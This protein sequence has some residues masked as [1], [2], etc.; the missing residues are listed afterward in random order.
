MNLIF[1]M[2]LTIFFANRASRLMP[3]DLASKSMRVLPTDLDVQMHMNNGRFLSIMDLGRVDLMVRLGFWGIARQRGWYPLVGSVK[4]DYRRPLTVFQ[5][6]DM[7]T[8]IV[9]WDDRWVFVEQQLL[10]DGKLCA[11]AMF[12]TMI[13]CKEG[14]VTPQEVMGVTGHSFMQPA[15]TDEMKALL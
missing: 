11:R 14:L 7:T 12:K 15:L 6:F 8:Q 4:T 3:L 10:S 2:L 13:R 5:K 9:G 1:R